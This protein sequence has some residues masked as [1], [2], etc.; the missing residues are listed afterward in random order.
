MW[1]R[2]RI[3]R[4]DECA[5]REPQSHAES[6]AHGSLAVPIAVDLVDCLPKIFQQSRKDTYDPYTEGFPTDYAIAG[7]TR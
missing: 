3:E 7:L 5:D 1:G 2:I 6:V 4:D